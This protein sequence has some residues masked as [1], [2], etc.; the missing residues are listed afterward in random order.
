[1]IKTIKHLEPYEAPEICALA[2]HTHSCIA[3]VSLSGSTED[4]GGESPNE[5]YNEIDGTW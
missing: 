2:V 4:V 3:A 5:S 1:M